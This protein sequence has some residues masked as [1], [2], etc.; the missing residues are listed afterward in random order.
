[1]HSLSMA[2]S[3]LQA[4]L[5][6][7]GNHEGKRVKAISVK[8][9]DGELVESESL[10]FCLEAM[11]KGTIAEGA[12]IEVELVGATARCPEC[13]CAF[14]VEGHEPACTCRSEETPEMPAGEEPLLV[15]LELD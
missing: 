3:I 2:Q 5:M 11:A 9:G 4:V 8:T 10:R 14:P 1:M 12:R 7:A 6:E 13:T 15:T